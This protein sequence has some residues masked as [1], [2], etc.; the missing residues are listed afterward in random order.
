MV[1]KQEGE[2][3]NKEIKWMNEG[4]RERWIKRQNERHMVI[5][6]RQKEKNIDEIIQ[7]KRLREKGDDEKN[8]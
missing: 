7:R 4:M 3:R 5:N 1:M 8:K 6:E 2:G